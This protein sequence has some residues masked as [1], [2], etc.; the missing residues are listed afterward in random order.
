MN[1]WRFAIT[2]PA[3][4]AG[5]LSPSFL[6]AGY[7]CDIDDDQRLGLAET[8]YFLQTISGAHAEGAD[9][10]LNC[11]A[12]V[13]DIPGSGILNPAAQRYIL[14]RMNQI[15]S[16]TALGLTPDDGTSGFYPVAADMPRMRWDEDLATVA[17]EYAAQC[18]YG[19]NPNRHDDFAE[20]TGIVEPLVGE[21][22]AG[23]GI[24]R[25][26]GSVEAVKAIETAFNNWNGEST[27][28]HYDTINGTSLAA[29]IGHFTQNVWAS[30]T[31]VGCGQAWCPDMPIGDSNYNVIFT[32]CNFYPAG[33]YSGQYPYQSGTE[34]CSSTSPPEDTCEN[35]LVTPV[36]YDAGI[37][38]ECDI[39]GDERIGLEEVIN[40]LRTL[41]GI[42]TE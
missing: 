9:T 35:G 40:A 4:I 27:L 2:Y 7:Q 21:N 14:C 18:E 1:N 20:L 37:P 19:H 6:S 30:S 25:T 24:S 13:Y 8:I 38:Y 36:D 41:S 10:I 17:R 34:V 39:N 12:P 32:V 16:E 42:T 22:I 26:I 3:L 33:N 29:G 5:M 31:R 28:W 23:T 11:G 15:R